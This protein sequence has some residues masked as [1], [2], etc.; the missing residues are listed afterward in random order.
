MLLQ[1][2]VHGAPDR[3]MVDEEVREPQGRDVCLSD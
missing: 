1:E 2:A 3:V